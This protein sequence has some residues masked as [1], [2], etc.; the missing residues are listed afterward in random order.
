MKAYRH[1]SLFGEPLDVGGARLRW[2]LPSL[3]GAC[4]TALVVVL[5]NELLTGTTRLW[6][7]LVCVSLAG[8]LTLLLGAILVV[9]LGLTDFFRRARRKHMLPQ[10]LLGLLGFIAV[11]WIGVW[12][13]VSIP[14]FS[15][16]VDTTAMGVGI[17]FDLLSGIALILWLVGVPFRILRH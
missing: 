2:I 3:F 7:V 10:V 5:R 15:K 4:L 17:V 9:L 16:I 12:G 8:T 13:Y 14:T 1:D 11:L 6:A